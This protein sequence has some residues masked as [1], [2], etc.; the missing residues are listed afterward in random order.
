MRGGA[1]NKNRYV[2][3]IKRNFNEGH[4]FKKLKQIQTTHKEWVA[5]RQPCAR[6]LAISRYTPMHLQHLGESLRARAQVDLIEL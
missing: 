5:R 2:Y 1:E 3:S 4:A 6:R